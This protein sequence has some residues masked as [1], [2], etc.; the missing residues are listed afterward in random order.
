MPA[1]VSCTSHDRTTNLEF[2]TIA[3]ATSWY[4][5][6][7]GRREQARPNEPPRYYLSGAVGQYLTSVRGRPAMSKEKGEEEKWR[8]VEGRSIASN[9]PLLDGGEYFILDT[10][11]RMIAARPDP[12]T[13]VRNRQR[14]ATKEA[15]VIAVPHKYSNTSA[16]FVA[17][18]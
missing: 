11:D 18:R 10:Y 1:Y 17:Q 4:D 13:V 8:L 9:W 15:E 6:G 5:V 3:E 16:S 2:W 14:S 7:T 12:R